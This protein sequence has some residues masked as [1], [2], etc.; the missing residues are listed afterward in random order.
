MS[1]PYKRLSLEP[2]QKA[3]PVSASMP[4]SLRAYLGL[5]MA[6]HMEQIEQQAIT[7]IGEIL[8]MDDM[9]ELKANSERAKRKQ[10]I[11][12]ENNEF[13]KNY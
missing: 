3:P 11:E 4:I 5:S 7:T 6:Y 2:T 9:P 1:G 12:N 10:R 13:K 8:K